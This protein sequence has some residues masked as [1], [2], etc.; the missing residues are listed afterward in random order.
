MR[1][2]CKDSK[3]LHN[4]PRQVLLFLAG[5]LLYSL[6][7]GLFE[8]LTRREFSHHAQVALVPSFFA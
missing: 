3:F 8:N 2:I 5:V 4:L 6:V 1:E 7:I